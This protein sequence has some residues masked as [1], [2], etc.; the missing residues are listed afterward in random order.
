ME[1]IKFIYT[2]NDTDNEQTDE[3]RIEMETKNSDGIHG[4]E[5][6]EVFENFMRAVG[7]SEDTVVNYFKN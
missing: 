3:C 5:V 7:F 4:P 6:C 1:R 2:Y